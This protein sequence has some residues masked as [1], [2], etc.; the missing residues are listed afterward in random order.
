MKEKE[1]QFSPFFVLE[2]SFL[3]S[4]FGSLI[5]EDFCEDFEV[6]EFF[7]QRQRRVHEWLLSVLMGAKRSVKPCNFTLPVL[8]KVKNA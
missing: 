3:N 4:S 1:G 8:R 7:E 2:K 5:V 6:L